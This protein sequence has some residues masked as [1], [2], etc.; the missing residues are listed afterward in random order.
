MK[1]QVKMISFNSKSMDDA[2]ARVLNRVAVEGIRIFKHEV[3][4]RGLVKSRTLVN[5]IGAVV[6]KNSVTFDINADYAGI[7]N[8][9]VRRHKMTYLVNKGPIPITKRGHTFFRMATTKNIRKPNL[10]LHPGFKKGKGFF[11]DGVN[12]IQSACMEIMADESLI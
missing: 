4:R 2:K 5:S 6:K 9:G 7:L 10:W 12:K 8:D 1:F 11:D 3:R